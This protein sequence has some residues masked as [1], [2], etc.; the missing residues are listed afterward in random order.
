[1]KIGLVCIVKNGKY[2]IKEWATWH[3]KLGFDKIFIFNNDNLG[4]NSLYEILDDLVKNGNVEIFDRR[5]IPFKLD[6]EYNIQI[7]AYNK[8][9]NEQKN[10][11]RQK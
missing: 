1:M 10:I 11:S 6:R 3:L 9:L 4:D 8:I 2:Y 5:G 7:K